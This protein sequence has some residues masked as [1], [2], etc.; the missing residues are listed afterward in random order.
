MSRKNDMKP[1]IPLIIIA[2]FVKSHAVLPYIQTK[3]HRNVCVS[4][5]ASI[6][7]C[8]SNGTVA[9]FSGYEPEVFKNVATMLS[10]AG[11]SEWNSGNW[12][13]YCCDYNNMLLDI[14]RTAPS[15]FCDVAMGAILPSDLSYLNDTVM[16]SYTTYQTSFAVMI[17]KPPSNSFWVFLS[18]FTTAMWCLTFLSAVAVALCLLALEYSWNRMLKQQA[19]AEKQETL[20]WRQLWSWYSLLQYA[21]TGL[22][23]QGLFILTPASPGGEL[24]VLGAAFSAMLLVGLYMGAYASQITVLN[25]KPQISSIA[26]LINI[27]VGVCESNLVAIDYLS[28]KLE[29]LVAL[30]CRSVGNE[31]TMLRMLRQG[32]VTAVIM[33]TPW[34]W[35]QKTQDCRY[36]QIGAPFAIG[37]Y[38]YVLPDDVP[39]SYQLNINL[40]LQ[41]LH[42]NGVKA[43][44][45]NL[46]LSPVPNCDVS[47]S[48][49]TQIRLADVGGLWIIYAACLGL[50]V[51]WNCVEGFSGKR[52]QCST[53]EAAD[54]PQS[55]SEGQTAAQAESQND[56]RRR[57]MD[58]LRTPLLVTMEDAVQDV[59]WKL[60][61]V[62][63]DI[64]LLS[65]GFDAAIDQHVH[66]LS[67]E[68][69][70]VVAHQM[71]KAVAAM[72]PA[73]AAGGR[74]NGKQQQQQQAAHTA[75][76]AASVASSRQQQQQQPV[77]AGKAASIASTYRGE[78][79][80]KALQKMD[81]DISR[82]AS[83]FTAGKSSPVKDDRIA[84][85]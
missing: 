29:K 17:Y 43:N 24:V 35:Y 39:Y 14:G 20:P 67:R 16:R 61:E 34:V 7:I 28:S 41:Q 13:F 49:S 55:Q 19:E 84:G 52:K 65:A 1:S 51:V 75:G 72:V 31:E 48:A 38:S 60:L 2:W 11:F 46:F 81:A 69:A 26:D 58:P 45:Q 77:A 37:S 82:L 56:K 3:S 25:L 10:S 66:S 54:F 71:K 30:P 36:V 63:R 76:K 8:G 27:P 50:A 18:P 79:E 23:L 62:E 74:S 83:D 80:A 5:F 85:T 53:E 40:F 44:L 6:D 4:S 32:L 15:R 22:S 59:S 9:S 70:S 42:Y 33:D 47:G 73:A 64:T 78:R 68:L 57:S 12:T 21:T